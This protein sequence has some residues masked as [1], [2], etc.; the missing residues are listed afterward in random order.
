M[1][2]PIQIDYAESVRVGMKVELKIPGSGLGDARFKKIVGCLRDMGK[3]CWENFGWKMDFVIDQEDL[4]SGA[5][6]YFL[7]TRRVG[8]WRRILNGLSRN[9]GY[10][11]FG[12]LCFREQKCD[13]GWTAPSENGRREFQFDFADLDGVPE[14]LAKIFETSVTGQVLREL[15]GKVSAQ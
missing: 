3:Q 11:L 8:G 9:G 5:S 2:N 14:S 15:F 10:R 12:L 6:I 7:R 1:N 13:A 4:S